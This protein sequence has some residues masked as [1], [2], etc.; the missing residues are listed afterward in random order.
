MTCRIRHRR[1]A[2]FRAADEGKP[3]EAEGVDDRLE[4]PDECINGERGVVPIRKTVP[5]IIVMNEGMILGEFFGPVTPDRAFPAVSKMAEPVRRPHHRG[6]IADTGIRDT[7]II[8]GLA[9]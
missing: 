9:T 5:A 1:R 4:V 7:D 6:A 8:R 3:I 2:A